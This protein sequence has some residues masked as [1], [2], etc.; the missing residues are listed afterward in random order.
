MPI[1]PASR[2]AE[3]E[4]W[5][6][7]AH[8]QFQWGGRSRRITVRGQ[9]ELTYETLSKKQTKAKRGAGLKWYSTC[10]TSERC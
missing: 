8:L 3:T 5:Q 10:L 1:I 7:G 6:D 2:E 4:G 9:P